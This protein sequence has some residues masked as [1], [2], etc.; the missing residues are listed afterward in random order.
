MNRVL[1]I[2]KPK[3][4][5]SHDVVARVRETLDMETMLK[6]AAQEV[7]QALNLPEVTIRLA[8]RRTDKDGNGARKRDGKEQN[9][10]NPYR[11]QSPDG[12]ND[13]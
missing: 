8:P 5:T 12:G 7:R 2:D 11:G 13:V 6:T 4:L 3:G 9:D 1:V 10:K